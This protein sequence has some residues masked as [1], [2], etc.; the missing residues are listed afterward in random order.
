MTL[1]PNQTFADPFC[2]VL[3]YDSKGQGD[4]SKTVGDQHNESWSKEILKYIDSVEVTAKV[5]GADSIGDYSLVLNP[6]LDVAKAW[7]DKKDGKGE[8]LKI[9]VFVGMRFGYRNGDETVEFRG[10]LTFPAID[11]N[12]T[13]PTITLSGAVA[14]KISWESPGSIDC[15]GRK[16]EDIIYEK[17]QQLGYD[18]S[19]VVLTN[20]FKN[21]LKP[22]FDDSVILSGQNLNGFVNETLPKMIKSLEFGKGIGN[23]SLKEIPSIKVSGGEITFDMFPITKVPPKMIFQFMGRYNLN[24]VSGP[25]IV[26]IN[27]FKIPINWTN[28]DGKNHVPSVSG[29]I[30]DAGTI[31]EKTSAE[32]KKTTDSNLA[33]TRTTESAEAEQRKLD[34]GKGRYLA[35][36]A[37]IDTIG[38]PT[39]DI[40][41][42][43]QINNAG[44]LID[45]AQW[46][47]H[48]VTHKWNKQGYASSWF[49][50]LV[51]A[52]KLLTAQ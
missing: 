48:R 20:K 41:D 36:N 18:R 22:T 30:T 46:R 25:Q 10:N 40:D 16:C 51:D 47:I 14:G 19:K 4:W 6:P 49:L 38:I 1:S 8:W 11:L 44:E 43:V 2:R 52:S 24:P 28:F 37:T 33:T 45:N 12:P 3:L 35:I 50:L 23:V 31:I 15:K 7:L 42:T 5:P 9:G 17:M 34:M 21:Y 29:N 39:L 26:P 32:A 27:N 13:S